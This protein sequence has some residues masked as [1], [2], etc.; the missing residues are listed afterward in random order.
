M[1][2][3]SVKTAADGVI[4]NGGTVSPAKVVPVRNT[5]PK[6]A[7][8]LEAARVTIVQDYFSD[9]AT[10]DEAVGQ[11][12][13]LLVVADVI[14]GSK[15]PVLKQALAPVEAAINANIKKIGALA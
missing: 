14:N 5:T 1:I 6:E 4:G 11:L 8:I 7:T 9:K 3:N 10:A 13:G 15:A 12:K 2:K